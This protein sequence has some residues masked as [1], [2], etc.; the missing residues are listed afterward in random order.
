MGKTD[1]PEPRRKKEKLL[2]SVGRGAGCRVR[3]ELSLFWPPEETPI[4]S[5]SRSFCRCSTAGLPHLERRLQYFSAR[6]KKIRGTRH[7]DRV[8]DVLDRSRF[9]PR[10]TTAQNRPGS[11]TAH[12]AN[13]EFLSSSYQARGSAFAEHTSKSSSK[14]WSIFCVRR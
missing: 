3:R 13:A 8:S 1:S 4:P 2:R 7:Q 12:T 5:I 10:L 11:Y 6:P 9:R 14:R